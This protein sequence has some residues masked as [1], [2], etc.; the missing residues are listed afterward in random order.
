MINRPHNG[1]YFRTVELSATEDKYATVVTKLAAET[2]IKIPD[3]NDA[4]DL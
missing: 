2:S 4:F 1:L 3:R